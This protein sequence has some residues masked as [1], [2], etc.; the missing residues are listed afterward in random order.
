MTIA[1]YLKARQ[2]SIADLSEMSGVSAATLRNAR[3]GVHLV[4]YALARRLELATDGEI[5]VQD[6]CDPT[7]SIERELKEEQRQRKRR[8]A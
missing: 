1:Q 2:L 6:A 5:T 3:N 4:H 8:A 7:R